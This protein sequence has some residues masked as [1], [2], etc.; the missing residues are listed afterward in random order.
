MPMGLSGTQN[1]LHLKGSYDAALE[2]ERATWAARNDGAVLAALARGYAEAGY[3]GAFRRVADTLA[4]R[5]RVNHTAP[6]AVAVHYLKAG[7]L[8]LAM[9]WL[10][11]SYQEREPNLPYINVSPIYDSLRGE[12]RF[13]DLLRRM[14]L[15][16]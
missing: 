2:A 4:A 8:G 9:D 5:A 1:A 13:Q 16:Q 6:L 3:P 11:R 12:A 15:P 7:E 14:K 10:E